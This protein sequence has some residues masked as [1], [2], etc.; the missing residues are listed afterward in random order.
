MSAMPSWNRCRSAAVAAAAWWTCISGAPVHA[1]TVERFTADTVIAIDTFDGENVSSQPQVIIDASTGFRVGENW[2]L[3]VRPWLRQ[4]RPT[5]P[6]GPAPDL[7]VQ[8]YQ[9][10][11]RYERR[12]AVATRVELGQIVSPVGLGMLDWRPNLN[13]TIAPHIAYLVPMPAFDAGVPRQLPIAQNYPLG[14]AVTVSTPRWDARAA[15]VN[16]S[17][18]RAWA[19]GAEGNPDSTAVIAGGAGVTPVMG[20]RIGASFAHGKYASRAE[21]PQSEHGLAMTLVGGE[22]E[23]AFRYTRL[24]GEIVRT[25]FQTVGGSTAA[26]EYFV[27]GLQTLTPRWFAAA[28]HEGVSARRRLRTFEGTAGWRWT[29]ELTVRGSYYARRSYTASHW[30]NQVAVSLVWSRRWR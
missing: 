14:A 27:Q 6:G 12:G 22:A 3:F 5:I 21:V 28:R 8:L 7:S 9:A 4:P 10:G 18:T 26:Y 15:L 1:Q 23:Y 20:L 25:T 11:A 17:P 19:I 16:A 13:P 30:D 2:Q 24:S 29:P